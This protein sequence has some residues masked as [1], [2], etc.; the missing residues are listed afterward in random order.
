MFHSL[1]RESLSSGSESLIWPS[2]CLEPNSKPNFEAQQF[3]APINRLAIV[4]QS[5]GEYVKSYLYRF[6]TELSSMRISLV[7]NISEDIT[8][9]L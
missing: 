3:S 8:W 5:D 4:H 7:R 9:P 2:E 6:I 1:Y